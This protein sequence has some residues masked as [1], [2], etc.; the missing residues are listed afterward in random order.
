[1]TSPRLLLV[2][3]DPDMG[4]VVRILARR[5]GHTLT[6]RL[7]AENAWTNLDGDRPDLILLDV[8]L[9]GTSGLEFLKRLRASVTY[10]TLP[11]ALFVQASLT[12]DIAEGWASGADYTSRRIS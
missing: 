7:D 11:V 9:P 3:D 5:C 2:D 10:A 8:N 12:R 6:H 1:M 4:F